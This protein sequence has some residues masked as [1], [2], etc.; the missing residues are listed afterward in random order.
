MI[1]LDGNLRILSPS[2]LSSWIFWNRSDSKIKINYYSLFGE[3]FEI[4]IQFDPKNLKTIYC[5]SNSGEFEPK[6]K[7]LFNAKATYVN[8]D[9]TIQ[10]NQIALEIGGSYLN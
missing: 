10:M 3:R 1:K 9:Q 6:S 5:P 7:Q 4:D 2:D 8:H